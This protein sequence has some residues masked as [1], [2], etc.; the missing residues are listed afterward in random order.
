MI[1]ICGITA[2]YTKK[3][4]KK[5]KNIFLDVLRK[6][7]SRGGDSVG[8]YIY[9]YDTKRDSLIY[10]LKRSSKPIARALN[11]AFNSI[12][13]H[14]IVILAH[15]RLTATGSTSDYHPATYYKRKY[16]IH[17]GVMD[18]LEFDIKMNDTYS[19]IKLFE[20]QG[21]KP[22]LRDKITCNGSAWLIFDKENE[23]LNIG[24]IGYNPLQILFRKNSVFFSSIG[25]EKYNGRN[26]VNYQN[27]FLKLD[28][29]NL[30]FIDVPE[31]VSEN[32]YIYY[33]DS[34]YRNL[35]DKFKNLD[36]GDRKK[37]NFDNEKLGEYFNEK[38]GCFNCWN[39]GKCKEYESEF[40]EYECKIFNC[41][42]CN[43]CNICYEEYALNKNLLNK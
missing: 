26:L 24:K 22:K 35:N 38:S 14:E 9:D 34:Y 17:N 11:K 43:Q 19:A 33:S 40:M 13:Q 3:F 16:M 28:T 21:L 27:H 23:S 30:K 41:N 20:E 6:N 25:L 36:A 4:S 32:D 8:L 39:C 37:N 1:K 42:N 15:T 7:E 12:R 31:Y 2:L 18:S 29:D 10:T 5:E